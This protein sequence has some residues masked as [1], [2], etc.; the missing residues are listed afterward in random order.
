MRDSVNQ[1]NRIARFLRLVVL[2]PELL[3]VAKSFVRDHVE[4]LKGGACDCPRCKEALALI[5]K[6]EGGNDETPS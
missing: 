1:L 2:A 6:V 5:A 3:A 4:E